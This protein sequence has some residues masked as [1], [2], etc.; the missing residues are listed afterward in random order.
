MLL[1]QAAE[2]IDISDPQ[3]WGFRDDESNGGSL[4]PELK[5]RNFTISDGAPL[6]L[7]LFSNFARK[8]KSQSQGVFKIK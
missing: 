8:S 5:S 1:F 6:K 2:R 7:E 3:T 4:V